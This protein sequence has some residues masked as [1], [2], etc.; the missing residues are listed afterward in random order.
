MKGFDCSETTLAGIVAPDPVYKVSHVKIWSNFD[1][2]KDSRFLI[3]N[4]LH[5]PGSGACAL[6]YKTRLDSRRGPCEEYYLIR[7]HIQD[8]NK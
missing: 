8:K 1:R 5:G 3:A 4:R 6:L 7:K 2:S